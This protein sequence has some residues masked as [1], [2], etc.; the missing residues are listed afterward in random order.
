MAE[1]NEAALFATQELN[2]RT[3]PG[4]LSC[5]L[6]DDLSGFPLDVKLQSEHEMSAAGTLQGSNSE[7]IEPAEKSDEMGPVKFKP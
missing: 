6:E 3:E 4:F 1:M 2:Y 5:Q 7:E